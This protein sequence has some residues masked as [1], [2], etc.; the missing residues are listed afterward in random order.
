MALI[1]IILYFILGIF[2]YWTVRILWG[3]GKLLWNAYKIQRFMRDPIGEAQKRARKA[4]NRQQD[5]YDRQHQPEVR[6]KKIDPDVGEYVAFTDI[7]VAQ[8]TT[9][10]AD[11][12]TTTTVYHEQ[13]ITDIE[14]E[15]IP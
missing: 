12:S 11:G 4:Y 15:D 8:T 1:R 9:D 6:K 5:D 7:E 14:W 2:L 3:L 13:Q 10:P